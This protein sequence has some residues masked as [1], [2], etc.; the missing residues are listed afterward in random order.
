MTR[1]RLFTLGGGCMV[2]A[3]IGCCVL[4]VVIGLLSPDR[5]ATKSPATE[6]P[7]EATVTPAASPTAPVETPT[8]EASATAAEA[9]ATAM[10]TEPPPATATPEP[11]A[12][13][14][15]MEMMEA[16]PAATAGENTVNLRGGP[17]TNYDVAG[18]LEPGES[19][20]IIGR[21]ADSSWWQVSL[22]G[23]EPAWVAAQVVT[24]SNAG[25]DIPVI[26]APPIPTV[27][28]APAT[29]APATEA[30]PTEMPTPTAQP[31]EPAPAAVCECGFD[32][33]NCGD[34]GSHAEAQACFDYCRGQGRGDV[35]RL[36]KDNDGDACESLR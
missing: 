15:T 29:E 9:S 16:P 27:L 26:E 33:Y 13:T 1:K 23:G 10:P 8:A 25:D 12:A 19:L 34:F 21:N 11:P 20:E 36:D 7:I 28:P 6:R 3:F 32:A 2:V 4:L 30:P 31:T 18:S 14:P 35:H 24:A 22:P 17:G 5:P